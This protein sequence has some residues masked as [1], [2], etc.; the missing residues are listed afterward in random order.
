MSESKKNEPVN[1]E[2]GT[3]KPD[4]VGKDGTIPADPKGLAAGYTGEEST[5]EPEEDTE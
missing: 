5:F 4:G 2:E 3:T 1:D